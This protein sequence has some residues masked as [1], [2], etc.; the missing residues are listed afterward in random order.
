MIGSG[1]LAVV[2][3]LFSGNLSVNTNAK[4]GT[5]EV[6]NMNSQGQEADN[7]VVQVTY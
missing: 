7:I 4:N 2:N 1:R 5:I 6:Y 3:G